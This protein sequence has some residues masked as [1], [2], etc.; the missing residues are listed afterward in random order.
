M[1]EREKALLLRRC[2]WPRSMIRWSI[3]AS[4]GGWLRESSEGSLARSGLPWPK[5][6]KA[7]KSAFVQSSGELQISAART[8]Q[9]ERHR[10][11]EAELG[12]S[13]SAFRVAV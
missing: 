13:L 11:S 4:G 10:P 8:T 2:V 3:K 5:F 1:G 6:V 9:K 12:I 7:E